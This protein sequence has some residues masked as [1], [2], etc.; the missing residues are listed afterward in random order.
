MLRGAALPVLALP[1]LLGAVVSAAEDVVCRKLMDD[2]SLVA[3]TRTTKHRSEQP[4]AARA[5]VKPK[6]ET[7]GVTTTKNEQGMVWVW[8]EPR[9]P[10]VVEIYSLAVSV[11]AASKEDQAAPKVVWT[12]R[13]P[14]PVPFGG[15]FEF[16]DV[17]RQGERLFILFSEHYEVRLDVVKLNTEGDGRVLSSTHLFTVSQGCGPFVKAGRVLPVE[18]GLYVFLDRTALQEPQRCELWFVGEAEIKKVWGKREPSDKLNERA[19]VSP[20][21]PAGE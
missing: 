16:Y 11:K 8:A 14:V 1:V 18:G 4:P 7:S 2:G 9:E 6:V 3:L 15:R 19:M 13:M 17:A 12:K 5:P 10:D 21:L 20:S